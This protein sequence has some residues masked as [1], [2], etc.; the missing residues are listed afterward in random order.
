MV[1][2]KDQEKVVWWLAVYGA[3]MIDPFDRFEKHPRVEHIRTVPGGRRSLFDSNVKD[4]AA[5]AFDFVEE[6][7]REFPE[8]W[9]LANVVHSVETAPL[10]FP[11]GGGFP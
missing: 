5:E 10:L 2:V 9:I 7:I 8:F 11:E 3:E 4:E 6:T 1:F